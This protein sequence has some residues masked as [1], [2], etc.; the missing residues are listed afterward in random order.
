MRGSLR[1]SGARA[2]NLLWKMLS[3]IHISVEINGRSVRAFSRAVRMAERIEPG[4]S[5]SST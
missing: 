5:G 1:S 4:F 2:R 3:W